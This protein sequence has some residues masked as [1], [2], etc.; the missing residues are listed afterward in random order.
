M[1][2]QKVTDGI[3]SYRAIDWD[4]ELF[5]ELVPL[6]EGTT[7]NAYLVEG[8]EK[9]A[10]I[11]TIYPPKT[12]EFIAAIRKSGIKRIDYIVANHAEQD[13]SGSIPAVL[14]L[15]PEAKVVTNAKCKRF[16]MNTLPVDRDAFITVGDGH[17]LSLGDKTL[18][19]LVQ[20]L[21]PKL[22]AGFSLQSGLSIGYS[23]LLNC[24]FCG[25]TLS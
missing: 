24:L 17:S 10:L 9:T 21:S 8:S 7:Y 19:F 1:I 18:Q 22:T 2:P 25:A 16:I 20:Q 6:P 4:R 3:Y 23:F 15:F 14:E 11:D 13:H 5:D 12:A